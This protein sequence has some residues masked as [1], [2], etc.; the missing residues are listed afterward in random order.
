MR[1]DEKIALSVMVKV[2]GPY[3]GPAGSAGL[4]NPH[5]PRV[6]LMIPALETEGTVVGNHGSLAQV[7]EVPLVGPVEADQTD[8]VQV[9]HWKPGLCAQN[10]ARCHG[11]R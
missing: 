8:L 6:A 2:R 10:D 4:W 11:H 9:L 5:V 1:T 3:L 7:D